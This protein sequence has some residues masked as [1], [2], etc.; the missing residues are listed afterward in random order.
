MKISKIVAFVAVGAGMLAFGLVGT[1]SAHVAVNPSDVKTGTYQT[2]TVSVPTERDVPTVSIKLEIPMGLTNV[3]PTVKPGWTIQ[4][5]KH[6][7]GEETM[8]TAVTWTG[9][10]IDAGYRDEFTLRA[11]TPSQP[12]DLQ[13]KTYQTYQGG[14]VVSWDQ[15]PSDSEEGEDE[16]DSTAGPFSVTRITAVS[17]QDAAL[18]NVDSKAGDARQAADMALYAGIGGIV[19][20]LI[21]I[22]VAVARKRSSENI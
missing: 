6:V 4:T 14:A 13:W 8:I 19:L 17:D 11:K 20:A 7:E 15:Q 10:K 18:K 3:T 1:T 16:K 21:A 2:F 12:A 9:G 5:E 22:A